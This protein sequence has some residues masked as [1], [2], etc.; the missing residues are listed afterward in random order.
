MFPAMN[1]ETDV[2]VIGVGGAGAAIMD[3]VSARGID[4][5]GV[6]QFAVPHDRGSSY[7]GTRVIRTAY[8][9]HPRYVPLLQRA[10]QLWSDLRD[11]T[12]DELVQKIGVINVASP[13][14]PAMRTLLQ[15]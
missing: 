4:V 12:G 10:W 15:G 7:G 8:F 2:I 3:A 13:E 9:E 5:V 14:H 11:Q 6:E 1:L